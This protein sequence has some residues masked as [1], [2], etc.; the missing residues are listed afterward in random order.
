MKKKSL[1]NQYAETSIPNRIIPSSYVDKCIEAYQDLFTNGTLNDF[2]NSKTFSVAFSKDGDDDAGTGAD[3]GMEL[4]SWYKGFK[5]DSDFT[6]LMVCFG[7]YVN[8]DG[9][10]LPPN[11]SNYIKGTR[12]DGRPVIGSMT[13][14]LRPYHIE[15]AMDPKKPGVFRRK[16]GHRIPKKSNFLTT[17]SDFN[18]GDLQP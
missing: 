8:P 16:N 4:D 5:G 7:I 12:V 2:K 9:F 14:F 6:H 3:A 17:A 15:F 10:G 1:K 13:V 11:I 18:L